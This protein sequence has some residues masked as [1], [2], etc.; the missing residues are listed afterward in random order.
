MC[1]LAIF[2]PYLEKYL[3]FFVQFLNG[4]FVLLLSCRSC[5]N[6]LDVNP[7]SGI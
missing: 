3:K 7:F 6:I 2:I 5:L 1:L 4:L